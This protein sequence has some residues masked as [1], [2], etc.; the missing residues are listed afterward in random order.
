MTYLGGCP[1]SAWVGNR[2][3]Y[4]LNGLYFRLDEICFADKPYIV[5]EV[6]TLDDVMNNGME[7]ADPF[8]YDLSEEELE[9]EVML[10]LEEKPYPGD[11]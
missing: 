6:G 8:P 7:D 2:T 3:V 9:N 4:T 5:A 1:V 10:F 11:R